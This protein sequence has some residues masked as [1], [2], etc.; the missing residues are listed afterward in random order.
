MVVNILIKTLA[1]QGVLELALCF[2]FL[3]L[4]AKS[5]K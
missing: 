2:A 1:E 5:N 4:C 3:Y